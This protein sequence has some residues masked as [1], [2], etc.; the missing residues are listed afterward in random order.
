MRIGVIGAGPAG[1]TAA[2][3]LQQMGQTVELFEASGEVGGMA[4][5]FDLWGHRVDLGPHRFFSRDARINR[6]WHACIDPDVVQVDRQ[7]RIAYRGR[8]FDYPL[9]A[10][11]V[12]ANVGVADAIRCM[13][14]Y[15]RQKVA[16]TT[17]QGGAES[18]EAWVVSRFG[19]RL[20]EMFFKSYSE[21][22]WG[23]PCD[24]LDADFAAQRIRGF[25]LAQSLL[26]MSGL[27]RTKARTLVDQF[28]YPLAG[29]GAVYRRMAERF[30]AAGGRLHLN[31]PVAGVVASE[32][33]VD[34]IAMPDGRLERF[35]HVISTMPLTV[36]VASLVASLEAAGVPGAAAAASALAAPLARLKF[37]NTILVYLKV[38][39]ADLFADQWLYIHSPELAVGRVTNFRNFSPELAADD[40]ATVVSLEF[41]CNDDDAMWSLDDAVLIERATRELRALG[42]AGTAAVSAGQVVRVPRCY[43][44]YERGYRTAMEPVTAYLRGFGN[45]TPIGRYGAFKYNNQDHSILVG[46]LAAENIAGGAQ[47]DLWAVNTDYDDYQ[48]ASAAPDIPLSQ[49]A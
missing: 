22:L 5:S 10:G 19:R 48:E 18:F 35:D 31:T 21:K 43:P 23:I 44:V 33:R 14:S 39:A 26:A 41:W 17:A 30:E 11:N 1:L 12:V 40:G 36:L 29:S 47:H 28:A 37:R 38:E 6:F 2:L 42:L 46:L 15:A 20:F 34:G 16:P 3:R 7:T 9:R 8:F 27:A 4:R 24:A 13:A 25:S 49:A 32:G 45:L